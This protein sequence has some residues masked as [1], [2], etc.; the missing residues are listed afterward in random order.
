MAYGVVG[1]IWIEI[2]RDFEPQR[3]LAEEPAD[4]LVVVA[5]PVFV[6]PVSTSNSRRC[7]GRDW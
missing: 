7:T 5:R 4:V 6:V 2:R 3:V 1:D